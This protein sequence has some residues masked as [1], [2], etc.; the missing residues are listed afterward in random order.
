[1]ITLQLDNHQAGV[2]AA[3]L[4]DTQAVS[5]AQSQ[6][7]DTGAEAVDEAQL[8][9]L[10]ADLAPGDGE[11]PPVAGDDLNKAR[12]GM[13]PAMMQS[14]KFARERDRV[15]YFHRGGGRVTRWAI[16]DEE[17]AVATRLVQ[18][19]GSTFEA[20]VRALRGHR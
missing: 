20:A 1:M 14:A 3:L 9:G 11:P 12:K 16:G 15:R 4:Q 10:V 19:T 6:A 2:L 5:R 7:V 17:S 8:A 18:Q 13:T